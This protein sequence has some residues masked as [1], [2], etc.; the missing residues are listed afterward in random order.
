MQLCTVHSVPWQGRQAVTGGLK[1]GTVEQHLLTVWYTC[2]IC[3]CTICLCLLLAGM[4]HRLPLCSTQ[5]AAT[6]RMPCHEESAQLFSSGASSQQGTADCQSGGTRRLQLWRLSQLLLH[7]QL[8]GHGEAFILKGPCCARCC[9]S[10][11]VTM[12]AAVFLKRCLPH[13]SYNLYVCYAFH[14]V[15]QP[16]NV[17]A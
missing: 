8:P 11:A 10:T 4:I 13:W 14:G 16:A 12:C 15:H 7:R 2:C 9:L 6:A 3:C 1:G 5:H 17:C